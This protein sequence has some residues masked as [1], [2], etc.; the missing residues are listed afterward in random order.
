MSLSSKSVTLIS[1]AAALLVLLLSLMIAQDQAGSLFGKDAPAAG[2]RAA[3]SGYYHIDCTHDNSSALRLVRPMPEARYVY[4]EAYGWFDDTHFGTGN[5]AQIIADVETAVANGGGIVTISQSVR[6]GIT[7]YTGNY[8]V[9]GD[10]MPDE[11]TEA[12]LGIY[13]DW[14]IRFEQWQ[15]SLPRN[16]VGPFT[17][18]SIEDLPTQY[19]GFMEAATG[20]ERSVLFACFLGQVETADPPPH[21]WYEPGTPADGVTLPRVGRLINKS[22]QPLILTASG[23]EKVNWPLPLRLSPLPSGQSTWV[24][25][26]EETWYLR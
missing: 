2:S 19:I 20:I 1:R 10:L 18:F 4:S 14:S 8:L 11:A 25:D 7:G 24:F 9:S 16:L 17:P 15:G 21:L 22:F 12:A 3:R 23:W 26:S 5:P 6:E 13:M